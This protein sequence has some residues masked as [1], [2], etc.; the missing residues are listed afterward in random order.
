MDGFKIPVNIPQDLLLIHELIGTPEVQDVLKSVIPI[1]D[2][3]DADEDIESSG[4]EVA[5]EDEIDAV[6]K[7]VDVDSAE[8][9]KSRCVV[10]K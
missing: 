3:V 9:V 2:K 7:A 6:L 5:S 1:V 8:E 4:S 10:R